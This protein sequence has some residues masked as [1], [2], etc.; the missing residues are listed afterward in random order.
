MDL[1]KV[2]GEW[3]IADAKMLPVTD[4][5]PDNKEI[6]DLAN[7]Y[8]KIIDKDFFS[9]YSLSANQVITKINFNLGAMTS[10][11]YD[12]GVGKVFT[13]AF[14]YE[15][16]NFA[17]YV[18][19][20]GDEV[21]KSQ[22]PIL[23]TAN[24]VSRGG[25]F[26]PNI[27]AE[28]IYAAVNLGYGPDKTL[29]YPLCI[30]YVKGNELKDV[31]E[32]GQSVGEML[33][34]DVIMHFG[35]IKYTYSNYRIPGNR[36]S[37]VWVKNA[38]GGWEKPNSDK[39]YPIVTNYYIGQMSGSIPDLTFGLLNVEPK[40]ADGSLAC[41]GA[42]VCDLSDSVLLD[43]NGSEIKE[44]KSLVDYLSTFKT[45]PEN[46]K[47][48]DSGKI[49]MSTSNPLTYMENP[50][51]VFFIVLILICLI[52]IL[53]IVITVPIKYGIVLLIYAIIKNTRK[54]K[55]NKWQNHL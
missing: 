37:E 44:W 9:H 54:K 19:K 28:D 27:A 45:L 21:D 8:K 55:K 43:K 15:F 5:Y 41:K 42:D 52:I 16:T 48:A 33:K 20:K 13:D 14:G 4:N 6:K 39:L 32:I 47:N 18:G 29:T 1:E 50:N 40:K 10:T 24:G 26:A 38:L 2:N 51:K 53:I 25:F 30:F 23:L 17:Q 46:Y 12:E 3:K 34:D 31:M 35:N 11:G 22:L 7:N 36:V 49:K